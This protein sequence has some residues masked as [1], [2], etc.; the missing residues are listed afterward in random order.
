MT[1][2]IRFSIALFALASCTAS[3]LF[4]ARSA[5][6]EELSRDA[7]IKELNDAKDS[8]RIQAIR[9]AAKKG[10]TDAELV[11]ALCEALKDPLPEV[12]RA[13]AGALE[14]FGAAGRD[15]VPALIEAAPDKDF[16]TRAA[17][18]SALGT[19]APP[20]KTALPILIEALKDPSP[21]L[22]VVAVE[23]LRRHG[24]AAADAL[25]ALIEMALQEKHPDVINALVARLADCQPVSPELAPFFANALKGPVALRG[26][27]LEA[28]NKIG[29]KAVPAMVAQ[30]SSEFGF[31][32]RE[33]AAFLEKYPKES[34]A[35][36]PQLLLAL[37]DN[38]NTLRKSAAATLAAMGADALPALPDLL[39]MLGDAENPMR[40]AAAA[41]VLE[42]LGPA[43]CVAIPALLPMMQD[44]IHAN[45]TSAGKALAKMGP[46]G[47]DALLGLLASPRDDVR[48]SAV[49]A[50]GLCGDAA[51]P[52]LA[53]ALK[54][55]N[56]DTVAAA[57]TALERGG[58]ARGPA[59]APLIPLLRQKQSQQRQLAAA[60]LAKSGASVVKPL[61]EALQ[62]ST[63]DATDLRAAVTDVLGRVGAPAVAPL[64]EYIASAQKNCGDA[65]AP[66][67]A[68]PA[69]MELEHAKSCGQNVALYSAIEALGKIGTPSAEA[70]PLLMGMLTTLPVTAEVAKPA[71]NQAPAV[72][73]VPPYA[74]L[75]VAA[76]QALSGIGPRANAALPMLF[77]L[78]KDGESS[79]RN[80][81]GRAI[82]KIATGQE[83]IPQ[84][85]EIVERCDSGSVARALGAFQDAGMEALLAEFDSPSQSLRSKVAAVFYS[86]TP[87]GAY[88]FLAA[89]LKN[90]EPR[91]R[92]GAAMAL[93]EMR[94]MHK[95]TATNTPAAPVPPYMD[96]VLAAL[97]EAV[98]DSDPD[99]RVLAAYSYNKAIDP[100]DGEIVERIASG[101][102]QCA[103]DNRPRG[104][105]A[106]EFYNLEKAGRKAAPALPV[107]IR[108]AGVDNGTLP[109]A[110]ALI[111]QIGMT[112]DD[113]P[114][115]I[116]AL[117]DKNNYT[118]RA[119]LK[120]IEAL[121]PEARGGVGGL[122]EALGD[123]DDKQ[124]SKGIEAAFLAIGPDAVPPLIEA[125]KS[126]NLKKRFGVAQALSQMNLDG[127]ALGNIAELLLE[128]RPETRACAMTVLAT[129]LERAKYALPHVR[130]LLADTEKTTTRASQ[131]LFAVLGAE[132]APA[133][134]E[135]L[136]DRMPAIRARAAAALKPRGAD[137][138]PPEALKPLLALIN[139]DNPEVKTAVLKTLCAYQGCA[140]EIM[141]TANGGDQRRKPADPPRGFEVLGIARRRSTRCGGRGGGCRLK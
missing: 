103:V 17:I 81:A 60:A 63:D 29:A 11:T 56:A 66:K 52:G 2:K 44:K 53:Q 84:L 73:V 92:S 37:K 36:L 132:A 30:L 110:R 50:L 112:K 69:P 45:R 136:K 115:L 78:L 140:A 124:N 88:P 131:E 16:T 104:L 6:S 26:K 118:R 102:A 93:A 129:T 57:L 28:L 80:E 123:A 62:N 106:L 108:L 61:I 126:A 101:L 109:P 9:G 48:T 25:P 1:L 141:F 82:S 5:R 40:A 3:G 31:S 35:A 114:V 7:V 42:G 119:A 87:A 134:V 133:L 86:M 79:V 116:D 95:K 89:A 8:A 54:S 64:L 138:P 58:G 67:T 100:N 15:A 111:Q 19:L 122:I 117:K 38:D 68:G 107:L 94:R 77:E 135:T 18:L 130:E 127:E 51:L 34:A 41:D 20:A 12:R 33:A 23:A 75:D 21:Q 121:G 70:V 83:R 72:P 97:R 137:V 99:V 4:S 74:K 39:K 49:Q 65:Q 71:K 128:E 43:A 113:V 10:A 98:K 14:K 90:D 76:L 125:L 13:A 96:G 55:E 24:A 85:G 27:A 32:R 22:R 59:I 91:I 47:V 46:K 139:D 120:M 105:T